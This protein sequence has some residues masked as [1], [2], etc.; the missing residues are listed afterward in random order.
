[1]SSLSAMAPVFVP[2]A[3]V[4]TNGSQSGG[5]KDL[6]RVMKRNE[7]LE[8]KKNRLREKLVD[9]DKAVQD[10]REGEIP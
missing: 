9:A 6:E 5:Q 7:Y 1:M 10:L 4:T 8:G 3:L 2:S